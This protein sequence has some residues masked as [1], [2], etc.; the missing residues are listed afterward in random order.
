MA[1]A[2]LI[3][4]AERVEVDGMGQAQVERLR[5]VMA[6]QLARSPS[7]QDLVVIDQDGTSIVDGRPSTSQ[8]NIADRA[9]FQYHRTHRNSEPF[10]STVIRSRLTGT[11]VIVVSQRIDRPDGSFAGV[12]V[13]SV[14]VTYFQKFYA[15]LDVGLDG[16]LVGPGEQPGPDHQEDNDGQHFIDIDIG[17]GRDR[18]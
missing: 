15:S 14:N 8:V 2:N 3:S 1:G 4:L 5:R 7:L 6:R 16:V 18:G 9:Y 12:A 10:V 11:W 17:P 13:A